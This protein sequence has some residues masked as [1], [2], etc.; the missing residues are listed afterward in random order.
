MARLDLP[1]FVWIPLNRTT[2]WSVTIKSTDISDDIISAKFVR[3]IIGEEMG[4]EIELENSGE[5]YTG[6]F[7][8]GNVIQ[9]KMDYS[10]GSTVQFEGEIE[11]ID[12]RI[13]NFG[14]TLLIKGSH[15]TSKLLDNF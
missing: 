2:K 3:G 15:Y 6:E 10:D 13:G 1:T 11:G 4:C 5:A 14:Y 7:A 12:K 9:F 8:I